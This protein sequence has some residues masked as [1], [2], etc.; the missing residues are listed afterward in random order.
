MVA[1]LCTVGAYPSTASSI[2]SKLFPKLKK[3]AVV[4]V[5]KYTETDSSGL[6]WYFI[7]IPHPTEGFVFE[8]VP[9]GTFTRITEISK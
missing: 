9:K 4:E 8:F 7:R 3:G 2:P 5:M 6:K 1:W